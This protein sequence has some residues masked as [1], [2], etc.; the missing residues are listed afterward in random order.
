[1]PWGGEANK[2]TMPWR[3]AVSAK[4]AEMMD[5]MPLLT[6]PVSVDAEFVFPRPK[7]HFR[8]GKRDGELRD[9]PPFWHA[10]TPD[11]DKLQRAIGDALSGIVVRDDR[12]IAEWRV[13]KVYGAPAAATL[14]ITALEPCQV[15]AR[16]N[17]AGT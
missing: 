15:N 4:A 6:G 5:G 7:A 9:N 12:Q 8:T 1:M 3:A 14:L 10:I 2:N 17:E 11:L 16:G 13:R